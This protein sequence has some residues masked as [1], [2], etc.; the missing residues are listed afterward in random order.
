MMYI[1]II[2]IFGFNDPNSLQKFLN[3]D[4]RIRNWYQYGNVLAVLSTCTLS[5]MQA[6]F[7]PFFFGQTFVI[8]PASG[9]MTGG[10]MPAEFWNFINHPK[11]S[12]VWPPLQLVQAQP[13]STY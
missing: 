6:L 12:G 11:D 2:Y 10:N 4:S 5:E 1:Y 9:P 7:M 3:S 8:V 13:N